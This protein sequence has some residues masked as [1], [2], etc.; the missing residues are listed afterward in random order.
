MKVVV[1]GSGAMGSIFGA[2]LQDAGNEVTLIEVDPA[3]VEHVREVGITIIDAHEVSRVVSIDITDQPKDDVLSDMVLFFVKG[4]QTEAAARLVSPLVGP[5]TMLVTLQNG[6]GN[7]DTLRSVFDKNQI[8]VGNSVH[9]A[10][11]VGI[12]VVRHTGVQPTYLGPDET[13]LQTTVEVVARAF[14]GSGFVVE[15]LDRSAIVRQRWS[16]LVMNAAVL[17]V[18]ALC[19]LDTTPLGLFEPLSWLIDALVRECCNVAR[20][21]GVDLDPDERIHFTKGLL[22]SAGGRSSM[23]QDILLR[24]RTEIDTINGAV[25]RAASNHGVD[26][27]LNSVMLSL[28]KGREAGISKW[29]PV[30]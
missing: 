28:V 5:N 14:D 10:T 29:E 30:R 11:A 2:A 8:V 13:T 19:G 24:R 9:S 25:V 22:A 18:G 21:V 27:T 15:V 7:E 17:P 1:V 4:Y 23:V 3:L 16:K 26:A 12:G 20:K 6:I